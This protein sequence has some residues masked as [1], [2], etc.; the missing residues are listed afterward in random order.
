MVK[1]ERKATDSAYHE[2]TKILTSSAQLV[3]FLNQSDFVKARAKVEN[4][5]VQQIA[6]HFKFSQE[7]NLNQLI[8]SSFDRKEEDQLFVEYI[9][10]VNNQAHQTLNNELITKWKSLFEKRKITD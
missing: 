9:R 3:A 1:I 5:T 8:L 6:S 2:F 10:Y 7:N 4:E